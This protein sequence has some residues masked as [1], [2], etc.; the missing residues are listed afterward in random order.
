MFMKNCHGRT[1]RG[2]G[3][4]KKKGKRKKGEKRGK[5]E[6]GEKKRRKIYKKT[7]K[8]II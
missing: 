8:K 6:K 1:G 5:G 3:R 2:L 7:R 4:T